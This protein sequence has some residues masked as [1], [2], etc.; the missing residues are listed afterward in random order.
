MFSFKKLAFTAAVAFGALST[1]FAAP[2]VTEVA[3]CDACD[4]QKGV[5]GIL[6]DLQVKLDGPCAQLGSLVKAN[7]TVDVVTELVGEIKT[8]ISA[9]V[10]DVQALVGAEVDVILASATGTAHVTVVELTA[11]IAAVV[12]LVFGACGKV[13][14]VVDVTVKAQIVAILCALGEVVGALLCAVFALVGGLL[15]GLSASVYA[16]ISACIQVILT[17]NVHVLISLFGIVSL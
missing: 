9:A 1:A 3:R 13:L 14:A 17:L 6:V 12:N 8:S 10:V 15:V 11:V 5:H 7:A 2:A 4:A 16:A